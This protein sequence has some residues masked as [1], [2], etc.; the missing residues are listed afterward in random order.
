MKRLPREYKSF[1]SIPLNVKRKY[2]E[3]LQADKNHKAEQKISVF[4]KFGASGIGGIILGVIVFF[5][6]LIYGHLTPMFIGL[7][8][9]IV[10]II[11][12]KKWKKE[13]RDIDTYFN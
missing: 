8:L 6:G 4:V 1:T 13:K 2:E 9:L 12:V 11:L 3:E 5:R 10:G 7:G